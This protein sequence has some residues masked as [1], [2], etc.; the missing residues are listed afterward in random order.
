M[1]ETPAQDAW[2]AHLDQCDACNYDRDCMACESDGDGGH[3][4]NCV[5]APGKGAKLERAAD[6]ERQAQMPPKTDG[7]GNALIADALYY[8]QDLRTFVGNCGSW[9]APNGAGYV[10]CID[11]AG[12]Y[13]GD[14]VK[15]MRGTD[16]PWPVEY[17]LAHV[18]RHVRTDVPAFNRSNYKPGPRS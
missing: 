7:L 9:W 8:V 5:H 4:C 14:Q 2:M 3:S 12:Q 13:R 18:V 11:D 6:A 17:V 1:S 10:C 15:G 16:I